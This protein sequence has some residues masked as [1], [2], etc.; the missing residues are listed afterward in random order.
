MTQVYTFDD[1]ELL[2]QVNHTY[3]QV[4]DGLRREDFLSAEDANKLSLEYSVIVEQKSWLPPFL[5]KWVGMKDS[6][7]G[8]RLVRVV[9]REKHDD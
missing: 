2:K 9:G 3:V 7:I 4:I 5:A 8:V 1:T 6:Q